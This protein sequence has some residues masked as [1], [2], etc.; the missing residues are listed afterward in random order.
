MNKI[1]PT[2]L[3]EAI[4][5]IFVNPSQFASHEDGRMGWKFLARCAWSIETY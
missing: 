5:S 3:S 2:W 4:V 1:C